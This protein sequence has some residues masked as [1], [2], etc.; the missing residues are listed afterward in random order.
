MA[1]AGKNE[2]VYIGTAVTSTSFNINFA[3]AL[4]ISMLWSSHQWAHLCKICVWSIKVFP[5][6]DC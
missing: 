5:L 6:P 2:R 3:I 4:K 1:F